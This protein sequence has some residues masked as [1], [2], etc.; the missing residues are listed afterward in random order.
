MS[1]LDPF[2]AITTGFR[3]PLS[4]AFA[5]GARMAYQDLAPCVAHR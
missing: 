2:A 4:G 3:E 1:N 5:T